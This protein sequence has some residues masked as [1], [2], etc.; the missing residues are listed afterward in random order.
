MGTST[1]DLFKGSPFW[2]N[3]RKGLFVLQDYDW[4][5]TLNTLPQIFD[6]DQSIVEE[7]QTREQ[8]VLSLS[9]Q[10]IVNGEL[11]TGSLDSAIIEAGLPPNGHYNGEFLT[12]QWVYQF[13]ILEGVT[14][15]FWNKPL[16]EWPVSIVVLAEKKLRFLTYVAAVL[17]LLEE[18]QIKGAPTKESFMTLKPMVQARITKIIETLL[19]KTHDYG[20]SY[21]RHGLQGTIPRLWDKIARYAQLSA[22]GR[23][24]NYEPKTDAVK[25]LL[26][27]SVIAWSLVRELYM[28]ESHPVPELPTITINLNGKN[29]PLLRESISFEDIVEHVYGAGSKRMPT[30]IYHKKSGSGSLHRGQ[31]VSIEDGMRISAVETNCA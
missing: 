27:Y 30:V 6:I 25:D 14:N 31:K 21:R 4:E 2:Q 20:E 16:G 1:T 10:S 17:C 3:V 15:V 12:L 9:G 8:L 13:I 18:G 19:S 5:A 29:I 26:G 28:F 23:E 11:V 7:L 24:A 22:L